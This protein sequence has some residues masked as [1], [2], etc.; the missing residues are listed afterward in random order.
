ML[1]FAALA[2]AVS[3]KNTR[4]SATIR[5]VG[6][7]DWKASNPGAPSNVFFHS[8]RAPHLSF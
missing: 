1:Y 5:A 2:C 8:M 4:P 7:I 6:Q 3:G